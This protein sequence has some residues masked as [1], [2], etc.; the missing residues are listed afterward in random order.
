MSN[1]ALPEIERVKELLDY[2]PMSGEFTWRERRGGA[3]AAG[4]LAGM[5][6]PRGHRHITIDGSMYQASRLAWFYVTE[7]DPGELYV[8][9]IDGDVGNNSIKNL[10]I[11]DW[12]DVMQGKT[13][14]E[15]NQVGVKGVVKMGEK[16]KAQI[17]ANWNHF[18]LGSYNTAEEAAAAH[19]AA[20]RILHGKNWR[21]A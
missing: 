18:Y 13:V 19:Q 1:K 5:V 10:R 7:E 6:F 9:H 12:F 17:T 14:S 2:N 4:D 11:G 15:K 16:F 20:A 21:L 3:V 8:D